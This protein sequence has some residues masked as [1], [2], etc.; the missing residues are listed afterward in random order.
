MHQ[1]KPRERRRI[2]TKVAATGLVLG[3]IGVVAGFSTWS[4]FSSTATN[5]ANS[6]ESGSVILSDDDSNTS[7]FQ[8]TDLKP[9]EPGLAG[10]KCIKV[11]YS[12]SLSARVRL[13]AA[14]T[15][16]L[17]QYLNVKVTRGTMSTSSFPSCTGFSA[18]V[19]EYIAGQGGGVVY[20]GTLANLPSTYETGVSHPSSAWTN[21]TAAVYRFEVAVADD[22]NAQGKSATGVS[23]TWEAQNS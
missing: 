18:D 7:M 19:T 4:A 20:N 11:T 3:L 8:L 12:G 22:N 13:Y 23:F 15:G 14:S 16:S 9:G 17:G 1:S 5:D 6:F 2:R 10:A 21:G